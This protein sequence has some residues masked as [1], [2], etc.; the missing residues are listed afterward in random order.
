[1]DSPYYFTEWVVPPGGHSSHLTVAAM[2]NGAVVW[3]TPVTV[4]APCALSGDRLMM[5]QSPTTLDGLTEDDVATHRQAFT[6]S[7]VAVWSFGPA[8][9]VA[10]C[11]GSDHLIG[12]GPTGQV[13]WKTDLLC[14]PGEDAPFSFERSTVDLDS[15]ADLDIVSGEFLGAYSPFPPIG[16]CCIGRMFGGPITYAT[17]HA[18]QRGQCPGPGSETMFLGPYGASP[19]LTAATP[20]TGFD[21]SLRAI[22]VQR[23]AP[24]CS[25]PTISA[26]DERGVIRWT[27]PAEV[28]L[29]LSQPM[30]NDMATNGGVES[31][32]LIGINV[33]DGTLE[34]ID[35]P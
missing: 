27:M 19:W 17:A 14:P 11:D 8:G 13:A 31:S 21:F 32:A 20:L 6:T 18:P 15:G 10:G 3:Y 25:P 33:S 29:D 5:P 28:R 22:A 30:G 12:I 26:W 9:Y 24:T 7:T 2:R 23:A 35:L 1:S 4:H 16:A 34:L